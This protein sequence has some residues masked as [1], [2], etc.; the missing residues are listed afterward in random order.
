MEQLV[1]IYFG[2]QLLYLHTDFEYQENPKIDQICLGATL[3]RGTIL[4]SMVGQNLL[5][6]K[7]QYQQ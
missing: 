4:S 7:F 3:K 1:L 5:F 6:K 2:L